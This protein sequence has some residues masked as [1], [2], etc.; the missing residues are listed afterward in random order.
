M[1]K[2]V[3][4]SEEKQSLH[5]SDFPTHNHTMIGSGK[6][7]TMLGSNLT[8][9]NAGN[10]TNDDANLGLYYMAAMDVFEL[11]SR[12]ENQHLQ[13]GASLFEIYGGKLFDL[14]NERKP[15]KCLENHKGKVCFPRPE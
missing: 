10:A 15:V 9:H 2:Q 13:V 14:L 5:V 11:A 1:D 12:P 4:T 7:Y 6:T 3:R 8:G